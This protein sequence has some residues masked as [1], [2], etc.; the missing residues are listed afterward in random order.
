MKT[1]QKVGILTLLVFLVAAVR[2][3]FVWRE[4]N[5]PSTAQ[6]QAY[7]E[8]VPT[9]DDIV[10]IRKMYIDDVKSAK[11]LVG[12]PVWMKAGFQMAYFPY[13]GHR[14]DFAHKAGVIPSVEKLDVQ[15]IVQQAIPSDV[16]DSIPHGTKQIFAVFDKNGDKQ[17]YAV[18]IGF[19]KGSDLT[20]YCDDM[21]YY[22]DP[23]SMYKHWP[24]DV[25]K[26][27]DAH[28]AKSGMSELQATMSLGHIQRSDSADYGN[29]TVYYDSDGK[30]WA[31]SFSKD[32]ATS[33]KQE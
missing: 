18:P 26:T 31:I 12:K 21:F 5:A 4:R 15:D 14:I 11:A 19:A 17:Q 33:V 9:N 27:V 10:P 24:A 7:Q 6:K 2:I 1:W 29:R 28:Q 22:D 13:N 30:K 8:W 23:H 20:F 25:W 3:Y 32:K 16:Q